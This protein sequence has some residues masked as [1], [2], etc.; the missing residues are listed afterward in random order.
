MSTRKKVIKNEKIDNPRKER[1][2]AKNIFLIQ[3]HEYN[4]NI[5]ERK[6]DIMGTTKNVYTVTINKSPSCTCPDYVQRHKRCKHIFFVLTQIM[7][8]SAEREDIKSYSDEELD[9]MFNKI[10]MITENL[11][12]NAQCLEKFKS[13]SKNKNGEVDM[14]NI[15]EED[16]C[17]ICLGDLFVFTQ[18]DQEDEITYCKYSCGQC[19]HTKCFAM[20]N[21]QR[22]AI[23]CLYCQKDWISDKKQYISLD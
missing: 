3:T 13:I 17:P 20:Y 19:I 6:Y 9:D 10:P 5:K 4:K 21:S 23:K 16:I 11:K 12:V 2:K 8:V 22:E 18:R 7:K 15:E 14:K 1:G